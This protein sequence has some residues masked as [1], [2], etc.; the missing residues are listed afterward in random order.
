M[1]A[2]KEYAQA[3]GADLMTG[4]DTP[5][6]VMITVNTDVG[7]T[8]NATIGNIS[9]GTTAG[10][11]GGRVTITVYDGNVTDG[12]AGGANNVTAGSFV[13]AG[14]GFG[15]ADDPIEMAV[16]N[17]ESSAAGN[18]F[19]THTGHL[20][21][22]GITTTEDMWA[23]GAMTIVAQSPLTI[24]TDISAA[25]PITLT[26]SDG[27]VDSTTDDLTIAA[28]VTISSAAS[29]V[30]LNSGDDLWIHPTASVS[31]ATSITINVDPSTADNDATGSD[32]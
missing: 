8:G 14:A 21:V 26:A 19:I 2:R 12:D 22:G 4:N 29:S 9:A 1:W 16:S 3:L 10:P 15:T 18:F 25:G 24:A 11:T 23:A 32:G 31:A 27:A 17:I 7:G 6:A 5:E 13:F 28:G 30:T 20:T